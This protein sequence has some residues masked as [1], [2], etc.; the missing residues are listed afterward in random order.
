M[1][2]R[3]RAEF[4]GEEWLFETAGGKRYSRSYV[5]NQIAKL[6]QHVLGRKLSAHKLRHTFVT[7][8]LKETGRV[9]AVSQY[10]GH[11]D[12]QITLRIYGHDTF[13][14]ADV[15]GPEALA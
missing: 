13:S 5:S 3:I 15:L 14:P 7:N 6:T 11:S 10:V 4:Q 8:K 1:Y 2:E 12:V 9:K